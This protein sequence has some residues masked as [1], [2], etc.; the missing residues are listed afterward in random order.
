M[1]PIGKILI[2]GDIHL[3]SKSYG[4]HRDY[5]NESLHYFKKISDI[6]ENE[7]VT[8][9]I[10]TGDLTYGK[11]N[12]LEYRDAVEEELR[13]QYKQTNGNRYEVKGNHDS[14]TNGMTEYEFYVK[15]GLIK[16]S[17]NIDIGNLHI[18]MVDNSRVSFT[19]PNIVTGGNNVNV[20]IAHDYLKFRD[21]RLPNFGA[22]IELDNISNWYGVD[23]IICGHIHKILAFKGKIF[24]NN[25]GHDVTVHYPGCMSRPAWDDNLDETG[26]VDIIEVYSDGRIKIEVIEVELL[27]IN[28]SFITEE[29]ANRKEHVEEKENRVDI[30]DIVKALDSHDSMVGNPEDIIMAMQVDERYKAKAIQLLKEA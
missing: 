3:S 21:T 12:T 27:D 2:Y 16:K 26:Q 14:A 29:I 13:R 4:M 18:T 23:Y 6:A 28:Q 24:N 5:P 15:N 7:N 10:G 19:E 17:C 9:I 1:E 30:S 11:F 8:H 22:A 20:I 25:Y